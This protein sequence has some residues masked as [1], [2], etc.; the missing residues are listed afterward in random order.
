MRCWG[1]CVA[2]DIFS[3]AWGYLDLPS[4][5]ELQAYSEKCRHQAY[6]YGDRVYGIQFHPEITAEMIADWWEQPVNCGDVGTLTSPIDPHS[7]DPRSAAKRMLESWLAL[8]A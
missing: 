3:L 8:S 1:G 2:G 6:R 7:H 5:A 4:G